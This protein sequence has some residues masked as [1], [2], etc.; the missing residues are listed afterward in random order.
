MGPNGIGKTTLIH[1]VLGLT[2]RDGG[3]IIFDKVNVKDKL[4]LEM[5]KK[6]CYIPDSP[7]FLEYLTGLENLK[8]ISRIYNKDLSV[9]KIKKVMAEFDLEPNDETLVK[10][11][12][13]GMKTK[14][15][16][17]FIEIIDSS[18]IIMDEPTIGLDITSIEYLKN[19]ITEFKDRNKTILITSHD[20][21]FIRSIADEIYLLN[22]NQ[23]SLLFDI[24]QKSNIR[25][26]NV[27]TESILTTLGDTKLKEMEN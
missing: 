1:I 11:Y 2:N 27:L 17:C 3:S 22:N 12:S 9:P 8:Y 24:S 6:I 19:K 21:E 18:F 16:L 15:N 10:N 20:M 5:K 14:L 26:I 23:A 13:R 4:N 7:F 25:N